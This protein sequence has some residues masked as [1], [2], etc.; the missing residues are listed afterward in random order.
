MNSKMKML[1]DDSPD[2]FKKKTDE[3]HILKINDNY[4]YISK[5]TIT[6]THDKK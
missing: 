2:G 5:Y 1:Q 6:K 3:L 4:L